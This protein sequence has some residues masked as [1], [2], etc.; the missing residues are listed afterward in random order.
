VRLWVRL[1][2]GGEEVG[3]VVCQRT[4]EQVLRENLVLGSEEERWVVLRG[5]CA[6]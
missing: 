4:Q 2:F 6:F 3:M 5:F 1:S